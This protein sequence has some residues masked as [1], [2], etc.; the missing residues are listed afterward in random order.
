[1]DFDFDKVDYSGGKRSDKNAGMNAFT[2]KDE[3]DKS[4]GL[5]SSL[6]GKTSWADKLKKYVSSK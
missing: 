1:M 2:L 6:G 4:K 5:Q 3:D